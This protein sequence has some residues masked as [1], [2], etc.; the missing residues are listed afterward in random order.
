MHQDQEQGQGEPGGRGDCGTM[1]G[2]L[3]KYVSL[4]VRSFTTRAH[5]SVHQ[6]SWWSNNVLFT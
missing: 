5:A 4:R 6:S 2:Y 3:D 1:V